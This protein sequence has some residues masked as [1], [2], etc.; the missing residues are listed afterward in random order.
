MARPVRDSLDVTGDMVTET[1]AIFDTSGTIVDTVS[2][3]ALVVNF[4]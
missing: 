4:E 1:I 2:F 3:F